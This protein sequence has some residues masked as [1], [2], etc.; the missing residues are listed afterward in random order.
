M[1][2]IKFRY[3]LYQ[4]KMGV[5]EKNILDSLVALPMKCINGIHLKK[6]INQK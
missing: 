3:L 1:L 5:Y 2:K 6:V 4:F